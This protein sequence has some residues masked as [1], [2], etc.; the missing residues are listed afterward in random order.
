MT[1]EAEILDPG[2]GSTSYEEIKQSP[3]P[4]TQQLFNKAALLSP[5]LLNKSAGQPVLGVPRLTV[6]LHGIPVHL[7]L[8]TKPLLFTLERERS[9]RLYRDI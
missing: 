4:I 6:P 2:P 3:L 1:K 5:D 9:M 8:V 7:L